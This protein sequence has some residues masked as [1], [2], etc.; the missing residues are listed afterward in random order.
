MSIKALSIITL[1]ILVAS[2]LATLSISTEAQARTITIAV[3]LAHG[4]RDKYLDYIMGNITRVEVD[5]V[6]YSVN[7][8]VIKAGQTITDDLLA[9]VDILLI[10]Q[11]TTS[12]KPEEMEAILKWLKK[13]NKALYVAGDS[14]YGGG[15]ASIDAVNTL[16]EYIGVKLRLE[17]AGVYS[18]VGYTYKYKGYDRPTT[19][20]AYYRVLAFVEPD[21]APELWTHMLDEGI[22]KP[23]IM[24]GPTC[25]IWVDEAG[26]YRDLVK[27]TYPGVVRLVWFRRA[28][29]MDNNP[30]PPY[31]Y[32][33]FTYGEGTEWSF[34]GY[35]AEYWREYNSIITVA[36]ESLYGDYEPA[37]SS[38]YYG[39]ELDGPKFVTNLIRWWVKIITTPPPVK[40]VVLSFNDPEGDDKGTGKMTYPKADVF[41]P[42]VFDL[43]KFEVYT[44]PNFVYFRA[45]FKDLGG[46]PWNGPNGWSLQHIS[47]FILTTQRLYMNTTAPHLKVNI[48]PGWHYLLVAI[49]GW[50]NVAWPDGER[51]ALYSS[52][53]TLLMVE[54]DKLLDAYALPDLN[55]IEVKVYKPLLGGAED[56]ES[57][58][59]VVAVASHD[60]FGEY[61]VRGVGVE[62]E[63]WLIGGGDPR[64][65]AA[66]VQPRVL[67]LLAPT[68]EDQYSMLTSY[69]VDKKTPATVYMLSKT[70]LIMPPMVTV[71]V[72]ETK[73][74]EVTK[75]QTVEVIRTQTVISTLVQSTTYTTTETVTVPE[76]SWA[77]VAAVVGLIVG[78]AIGSLVRRK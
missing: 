14:D 27:E 59:F 29:I 64:A 78:I 57:W 44:D 73:T 63:E 12:F 31:K 69:D 42:G 52:N 77:I 53:G 20:G 37:W 76:Y 35:A 70:G 16:L 13:G 48:Y 61:K 66:G 33:V 9:N 2:T 50:G 18:Y 1:A 46:N 74:V 41:K 62:A 6:V 51:S 72:L 47:I 15:P 11:P 65:I 8:V 60:G 38:I 34:V 19:A 3:D 5:G 40:Q 25:V 28:Y 4:E 45:T 71:T 21:F 24:H 7:W 23:I 26:N 68:V 22:T 43:L 10:G 36:G 54:D 55:A 67:D 75:T 30:P 39:V 49:P 32:D 17:H 58:A 56:V